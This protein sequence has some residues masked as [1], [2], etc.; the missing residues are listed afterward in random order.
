MNYANLL[1]N[2][3]NY[4]IKNNICA[5]LT[6]IGD[7]F[8][9]SYSTRP[10]MEYLCNFFGSAGYAIIT[11]KDKIL[12]V[13]GRYTLQAKQQSCF[14]VDDMDNLHNYLNNYKQIAISAYLFSMQFLEK[15]MPKIIFLDEINFKY[16]LHFSAVNS[17]NLPV[18]YK[19][20]NHYLN[21][22]A[23]ENNSLICNSTLLN[24]LFNLRSLNLVKNNTSMLGYA[25]IKK[26]L[27]GCVIIYFTPHPIAQSI[28][29]SYNNI[30]NVKIVQVPINNLIDY[31]SFYTHFKG[32]DHVKLD[33][34]QSLAIFKIWLQKLQINIKNVTFTY[35][36][37]YKS[38]YQ[39]NS[40]KNWHK[41][42]ALAWLNIMYYIKNNSTLSENIIVNQFIKYK[43][44][45]KGYVGS[46][47]DTIC[48]FDHMGALVHYVPKNE[49]IYKKPNF[50]LLDAGSHYMLKNYKNLVFGA[51]TDITRCFIV[52]HNLKESTYINHYSRVLRANINVMLSKI[53]VKKTL[54]N[55]LDNRARTSFCP[56]LKAYQTLNFA[57]STGHGVGYML[58]VHDVFPCIG[59]R[60]LQVLDNNLVFSVEPGYYCQNN[61]GLRLENLVYVQNN[62]LIPLSLVPFE[63]RAIDF[64]LLEHV[65]RL[66]LKKYHRFIYYTLRDF[67]NKN[68]KFKKMFNNYIKCWF[69]KE[70][71][72]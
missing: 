9:Q 23:F 62:S 52:N 19:K 48:A 24:Y 71:F 5:M 42:E 58:N 36:Y 3:T 22:D 72:F 8:L 45:I 38:N 20:I 60:S 65:H 59:P 57:H 53:H 28:I 27:Q 7:E 25:L 34:A 39:L 14:V 33:P 47:F 43:Q 18:T 61:F 2:I 10:H 40:I 68:N 6:K 31:N 55:Q 54:A 51:T 66:W 44:Q 69:R 12:L 46:S 50:L 26:N 11:P 15:I 70:Y 4:L 21:V 30:K 64:C 1:E 32:L 35:K 56:K 49:I 16:L 63:L 29:N 17:Q 41:R 13:D 67:V 37:V